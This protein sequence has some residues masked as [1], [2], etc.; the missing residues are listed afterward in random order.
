MA[1]RTTTQAPSEPGLESDSHEP[2]EFVSAVG[3]LELPRGHRRVAELVFRL[4][5]EAQSPLK[6]ATAVGIGVFIGCIPIFGIHLLLVLLVAT[7]FRL[8][9]LRMYAATWISNPVFAPFLVWSE[10]Q[11]GNLILT[12]EGIDHSLEGVSKIGVVALGQALAIGSLLVGAGLGFLAAGVVWKLIPRGPEGTRRRRLIEET[13]H[14]YLGLGVVPWFQVRRLLYRSR[15]IVEL[16]ASGK[17]N[18]RR[19]L[20]DLECGRGEFIALLM[21]GSPHGLPDS[22]IGVTSTPS[23]ARQARK[24]LPSSVEIEVGHPGIRDLKSADTVVIW[25]TKDRHGPDI[26]ERLI[27][28]VR[29]S[30]NPSGVLLICWSKNNGPLEPDRVVQWL[31]SGGFVLEEPSLQKGWVQRENLILARVGELRS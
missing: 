15:K 12:G 22:C 4:F 11:L 16:V 19:K 27:K 26:N 21:G 10:L 8:S 31:E 30:I 28:T 29:A 20:V 6:Q 17:L 14:R 5:T 13:A 2:P 24:I 23:W 25:R 18:P 7:L 3:D 9:R 1:D